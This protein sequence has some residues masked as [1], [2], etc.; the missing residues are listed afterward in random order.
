MRAS[1]KTGLPPDVRQSETRRDGQIWSV[2][3]LFVLEY[4][5][6]CPSSSQLEIQPNLLRRNDSY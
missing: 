1:R 2:C 5:L 4:A 6:A 3:E